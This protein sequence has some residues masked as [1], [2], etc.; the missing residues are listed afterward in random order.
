MRCAFLRPLTW[1]AALLA[2]LPT[3]VLLTLSSVLAPL[4]WLPLARR[5]RIAAANL[6]LCF[7]QLAPAERARLLR[8]TLR[9]TVMGVF[10]LLRA[11]FAPSASLRG[12]VDIEGLPAMREALAQDK[13][14]LLLLGHF[15]HTELAVRFLG[16][17]LGRRLTGVVRRH[18]SPCIEAELEHA[19][20]RHFQPTLEKKDVRGV[21][22]ALQS[23][24]VVAYAAD[25]DFSFRN[26]FVPFFGVPASTLVGNGKLAARGDARVFALWCRRLPD[27]RYALRIEP[28][29]SEWREAAPEAQAAQYMR[30]LEA[31]VRLAPEQYLWVH[32][33]FKTRPPGAA[34]VYA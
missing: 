22:R 18:N 4:L 29:W 13:G 33:R 30:A 5:R 24:E 20:Q 7:P 21:L 19:R 26:A 27:G 28:E 15:P 11:W 1:S 17:A 8:A 32:R 34:P 9:S 23:G 10:E 12:S 14:V 2:R 25:Q 16:E 6:A 31:Q 3:R